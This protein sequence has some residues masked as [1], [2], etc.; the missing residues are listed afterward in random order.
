M[1]EPPCLSA[2]AVALLQDHLAKGSVQLLARHSWQ[3]D[4]CLRQGRVVEGRLWQ[5]TPPVELGLH[6]S[7]NTVRFL[8]WLTAAV[9]SPQ[10]GQDQPRIKDATV[11]DRLLFFWA[12]QAL[13]HSGVRDGLLRQPFVAQEPLCRLAFADDFVEEAGAI[14][15]RPWTT[16]LGSCILEALQRSLTA[17]LL[18]SEERKHQVRNAQAMRVLGKN[19]DA[20]LRGFC[21]AV[22]VAGRWDLAR[23]LLPV[24][25]R[26]TADYPDAADWIGNLDVT[27]LRLGERVDAYRATLAIFRLIER[28]QAWQREAQTLGYFDEGYPAGQLWKA[29]WEAHGGDE[30][31]ARAHAL[32][33]AVEPL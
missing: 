29:A 31:S 17:L 30:I 15:W 20:V 18:Q 7:A 6:F 11:A 1:D 24:L 13:R 33:R 14:D 28:L 22:H 21:D 3:R 23:F 27:K 5:R 26:L 16:G 32:L 9:P 2:E 25:A 8:L 4:R 12:Y 10:D 19:Q